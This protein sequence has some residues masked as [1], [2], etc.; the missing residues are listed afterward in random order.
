MECPI[1][2]VV[3]KKKNDKKLNSLC[4]LC[5]LV[6]EAV[7]SFFYRDGDDLIKIISLFDKFILCLS[8][9]IKMNE[10]L[11]QKRKIKQRIGD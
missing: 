2:L 8:K 6:S 3:M 5:Y 10:S 11:W 4:P 9:T 1:K 7:H